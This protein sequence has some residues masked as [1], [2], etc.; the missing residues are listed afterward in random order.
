MEKLKD[1]Q[2]VSVSKAENGY[3]IQMLNRYG[4]DGSPIVVLS[5]IDLVMIFAEAYG[6]E[7]FK[8]TI[9]ET[10]TLSKAFTGFFDKIISPKLLAI[11]AKI[12]PGIENLV[13]DEDKKKDL[14]Q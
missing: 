10:Q 14:S 11:E 13:E 2:S 5:F 8:N 4:S 7:E 6:E 12:N 1:G 9:V 3:V